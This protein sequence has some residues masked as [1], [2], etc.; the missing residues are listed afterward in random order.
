MVERPSPAP[1]CIFGGDYKLPLPGNGSEL[2]KD[3]ALEAFE[4]VKQDPNGRSDFHVA[5]EI[6]GI[7]VRHRTVSALADKRL[8]LSGR[9]AVARPRGVYSGLLNR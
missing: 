9:V 1:P 7:V 3:L 6:L 8:L 4:F 5:E 2:A